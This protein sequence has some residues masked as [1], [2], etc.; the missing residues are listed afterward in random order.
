M[1]KT[2]CL[3]A[4]QIYRSS[5]VWVVVG[6]VVTHFLAR[7]CIYGRPV[8]TGNKE[9][10]KNSSND[11]FNPSF[12]TDI[13]NIAQQLDRYAPG[14]R[15][16][17]SKYEIIGTYNTIWSVTECRK[18]KHAIGSASALESLT[19]GKPIWTGS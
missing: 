18:N 4:L 16:R 19:I 2:V 11:T 1:G 10:S 7:D 8:R 14:R 12:D 17:L 13:G 9:M 5:S 3:V 6:Q 15:H